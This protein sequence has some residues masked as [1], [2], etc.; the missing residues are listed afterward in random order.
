MEHTC[1]NC[2]FMYEKE[3]KSPSHPSLYFCRNKHNRQFQMNIISSWSTDKECSLTGTCHRWK[4]KEN[5]I[6]R[7]HKIFCG[8]KVK[9]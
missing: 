5:L 1:Q 8:R 4:T 9:C 7:I 3:K 2:R 6:S